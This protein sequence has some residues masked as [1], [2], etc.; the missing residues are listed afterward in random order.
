MLITKDRAF[1]RRF[2][3]HYRSPGGIYHSRFSLNSSDQGFRL[4]EDWMFAIVE[5]SILADH[6]KECLIHAY[7]VMADHVH[8][9]IQPLPRVNEVFHWCDCRAFYPL[10]R[11]TGRIKGRSSRLINKDCGRSGSLWQDESYDRTI[12]GGRD[13]EIT[14]EYL[15]NNPVRWKLVEFPEQYRWSSLRTIDSGDEKYRGWFDLQYVGE[16]NR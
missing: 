15:H 8:A 14:I 4:S 13:L 6:K 3:P 16:R 7:V 10:E 9:V 5:D 2:L 1:Y 11:I 12:R